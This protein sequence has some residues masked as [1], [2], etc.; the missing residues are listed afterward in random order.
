MKTIIGITGP[1]G[2][3]KDT[4]AQVLI[5][6]RGYQR[7]S[8]A[9]PIKA[10][11]AAGL[12]LTPEQLNDPAGKEAPIDWIIGQTPRQLMQ[13]LGTEWG[14]QLVHPDI[15]VRAMARMIESSPA[16]RIVI[17]DVRFENEAHAIRQMGGKI[18]RLE[19]RH[20]PTVP[21]HI[22]ESGIEPNPADWPLRNTGSIAA[23]QAAALTLALRAET[24]G[25]A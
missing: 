17:P 10:M 16:Q 18:I 11:L 13:T 9:D 14:R 24:R 21:G 1:A 20:N 6:V 22:S 2:A 15:W 8:F 12:G 7:M 5:D 3:G 25:A 4:A 23:L 19:G